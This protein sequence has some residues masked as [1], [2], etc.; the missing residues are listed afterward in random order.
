M[1]KKEYKKRKKKDAAA[2]DDADPDGRRLLLLHE[3]VIRVVHQA[4]V[5]VCGRESAP[6]SEYDQQQRQRQPEQ[7]AVADEEIQQWRTVELAKLSRNTVSVRS[8]D[9]VLQQASRSKL[10]DVEIRTATAYFQKYKTENGNRREHSQQSTTAA[11]LTLTSDLGVVR[12]VR[13]ARQFA[14]ELLLP[15]L[16]TALLHQQQE[17]IA[18]VH[19]VRVASNGFVC[20][21]TPALLRA[22]QQQH[23]HTTTTATHFA[24]WQP[25]PHCPQWCLDRKGLWWHLQRQHGALH[26][27]ATACATYQ[28]RRDATA[29]VVYQQQRPPQQRA[30]EPRPPQ[31][32][33]DQK[34]NG[35]FG[36]DNPGKQEQHQQQ[37]QE[38]IEQPSSVEVEVEKEEDPWMCVRRGGTVDELKAALRRTVRQRSNATGNDGDPEDSCTL[39]ARA[40][41]DRHGAPLLLW[42][43]GGGH[44]DLLRYFVQECGCHPDRTVQRGKRAFDGRTALHWAARKGHV[45]VVEYLLSFDDDDDV[46]DD[47]INE[48]AIH[49]RMEA[50]TADGTTAFCWAAWQAHRPV[51]KLLHQRGCRVDTC[52][53]FGCN[54]VLWAAQ[55]PGGGDPTLIEWLESVGCPS[56]LVNHSGHGVLHKAAQRGSRD[57]CEW[58]VQERLVPWLHEQLERHRHCQQEQQVQRERPKQQRQESLG[59]DDAEATFDKESKRTTL[60]VIVNVFKLIGPDNDDCTPSDL[61]GMED[62]ADLA[63]YLAHQEM[64]LVA[65]AAELFRKNVN[66]TSIPEWLQATAAAATVVGEQHFDW[67]PMG[68]VFRMQSMLPR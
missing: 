29:L 54:A 37:Q 43:A 22:V 55:G 27:A 66:T 39:W 34:T 68:G 30:P 13:S 23:H 61:A 38:Q 18:A 26:G 6:S 20:A 53:Q 44:A 65:R 2:D 21:A 47:G 31:L 1:R 60:K 64:A 45:D 24:Q 10:Y 33:T 7:E 25:C 62:H 46:D 35:P 11:T 16:E 52:N 51:L 67:E 15:I 42:A 56:H 36:F 48:Q 9:R 19:H 32:S 5:Q 50:A 8:V 3:T 4:L 58:F 57:L 12:T 17:E 14:F 41:R 63:V 59:T 28:C 40:A 49:K